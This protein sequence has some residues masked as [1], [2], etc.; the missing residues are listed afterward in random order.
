MTTSEERPTPDVPGNKIT[1]RYEW[2]LALV[3]IASVALCFWV[4]RI[5]RG[6]HPGLSERGVRQAD[7]CIDLSCGYVPMTEYFVQSVRGGELPLWNPYQVL[8]KPF[9]AYPL[10]W[11][12]PPSWLCLIA[13]MGVALQVLAVLH[14]VAAGFFTYW[15]CRTL[16]LAFAPSLAGGF[17]FVFCGFVLHN[18]SWSPVHAAAIAWVPL[19]FVCIARLFRDE[20][21]GWAVALWGVCAVQIL[22]GFLQYSLYMY[23]GLGG[24]MLVLAVSKYREGRDWKLVT[25]LVGLCVGAMVLG[26]LA[27]S[28]QLIPLQELAGQ[29]LRA[30]LGK[31]YGSGFE[32]GRGDIARHI[33][34]MLLPSRL[35]ITWAV[36]W[37]PVVAGLAGVFHRRRR[38][39]FFFGALVVA[40]V[41]LAAGRGSWLYDLY[42]RLPTGDMFVHAQ[43]F[44]LLYSFGI[45]VLA[46]MGLDL[47]AV[48]ANAD[49]GMR[50]WPV[51]T[52][53]VQFVLY[54]I[55]LALCVNVVRGMKLEG[56][57]WAAVVCALIALAV[58]VRILG[59]G[60]LLWRPLSVLCAV[61]LVWQVAT[62]FHYPFF[63]LNLD[64]SAYERSAGAF[65]YLKLNQGLSRAVNVIWNRQSLLES[66]FDFGFARKLGGLRGVYIFGDYDSLEDGRVARYVSWLNDGQTAEAITPSL[67]RPVPGKSALRLLNLVGVKHVVVTTSSGTAEL[68]LWEKLAAG[69]KGSDAL[70]LKLVFEDANA[71]IYENKNAMPRAYFVPEVQLVTDENEMLR[72][73]A[74]R[75]FDARRYAL[76]EDPSLLGP[77]GEA[78]A[79]ANASGQ[80]GLVEVDEYGSREVRLRVDAPS[81]GFVVLTDLY[82]PGW[83]AVADGMPAE[84]HRANYL[85]RMVRVDKGEH[86]IRF[87]YPGGTFYKGLVLSICSVV[88]TLVFVVV[89]RRVRKERGSGLL[90]PQ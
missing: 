8:G 71:T 18:A 51:A 41:L 85:F 56:R 29:S 65:E 69:G 60:R 31:S 14:L 45:A 59:R 88:I 16:K 47:L 53:V 86:T 30:A 54:A 76:V 2:A 68:S 64:Q 83:R 46:A 38:D 7:F 67:A 66:P 4:L 12:Y 70:A 87:V 75:E 44:S 27:A 82:Y 58:C 1:G 15:F 73:L 3:L 34:N 62:W 80:H 49:G 26:A 90:T 79:E 25:R 42:S 37:P 32:T 48:G 21:Q 81:D 74:S 72:T 52:R 84:I 19:G 11:F 33:H 17:S 55:A 6:I 20:T 43:R 89:G 50:K 23:Y 61:L 9:L 35:A 5:N 13:P 22:T 36:T 40:S 78:N 77:Q 24:Y 63:S 57:V 10:A 28:V 39:A